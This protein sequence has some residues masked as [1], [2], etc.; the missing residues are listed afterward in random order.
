MQTKKCIVLT[1][2]LCGQSLS[3]S[4]SRRCRDSNM[5]KLCLCAE[6]RFVWTKQKKQN[7]PPVY[8]YTNT[9]VYYKCHFSPFSFRAPTKPSTYSTFL[10]LTFAKPLLYENACWYKNKFKDGKMNK[11]KSVEDVRII[12]TDNYEYNL[13]EQCIFIFHLHPYCTW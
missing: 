4:H 12:K 1:N 11:M 8:K 3:H 10:W 6:K 9:K 2:L 5:L 13:N 7:V